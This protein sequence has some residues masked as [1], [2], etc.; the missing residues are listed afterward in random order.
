MGGKDFHEAVDGEIPGRRLEPAVEPTRRG[1]R[2]EGGGGVMPYQKELPAE[3]LVHSD[4]G[5]VDI[6]PQNLE[7]QFVDSD[8]PVGGLAILQHEEI[9][10]ERLRA[11]EIGPLAVGRPEVEGEPHGLFRVIAEAVAEGRP[12]L[13]LRVDGGDQPVVPD[14]EQV[15]LPG[16]PEE[17]GQQ[18]D[19]LFP[20]DEPLRNLGPGDRLTEK[21]DEA[22]HLRAPRH[23][24]AQPLIGLSARFLFL[25][26]GR[27]GLPVVGNRLGGAF[28]QVVYGVGLIHAATLTDSFLISHGE[29][30]EGSSCPSEVLRRNP[31]L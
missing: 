26:L 28:V 2:D 30:L 21:V 16:R 4:V 23:D 5:G 1:G 19:R 24:A 11:V 20:E 14:D 22:V 12:D 9:A 15:P 6:L 3:K 31:A 13:R 8:R 17:S 29:L 27:S 25:S 7:M 18:L 10:E